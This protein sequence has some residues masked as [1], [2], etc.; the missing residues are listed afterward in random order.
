MHAQTDHSYLS[1]RKNPNFLDWGTQP[2]SFKRYPHFYP[3]YET[4]GDVSFGL[5]GGI[6]MK[7]GY[8]DSHYY[9]RTVPSA[10]ALYPCE[11]YLQLRGQVGR[12]D[13]IYHYEPLHDKLTLIHELE[14]D[15]VE[16]YLGSEEKYGMTFLISS[17]YFRSSW[18]YRERAIRYILL[19]AGHQIGAVG[20][21]LN[22]GEKKWRLRFDGEWA[23]LNE[24]FGFEGS[25]FFLAAVTAEGRPAGKPVGHL[26]QKLPFVAPTDYI[27][28]NPFIEA[29][30]GRFLAEKST[31][32]TAE[33]LGC[34]SKETILQRRS[35]RQ[36]VEHRIERRIVDLIETM[37][38]E[39]NRFGIDLHMAVKAVEG[40]TT[41][42]Y[43]N[44]TLMAEGDF[45]KRCAYLALEQQIVAPA[46]I[47][48]FFSAGETEYFR[49]YILSGLYG[50][51]VYLYAQAEGLGC[52]GI[53]A[54]YDGETKEFLKSDKNILYAMIVG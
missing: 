2:Q 24:A 48:L 52:S 31:N 35:A 54:Y 9:L 15:G 21:M 18:K 4:E 30:Y 25:E 5:M 17:V 40:V 34:F 1:V 6:T 16:A 51:Q 3:R 27:E 26:R 7:K 37:R 53:G 50:H 28:R 13:G 10:G 45:S 22:L 36:F 12:V 44:G 47:T 43:R 19:D 33:T 8:G 49:N 23:T 46:N 38:E 32:V 29:G 14:G 41:G 42:L 11:I 39:M 20:A